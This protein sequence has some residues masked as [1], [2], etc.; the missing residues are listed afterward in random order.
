MSGGSRIWRNT[1]LQPAQISSQ[2]RNMINL[3]RKKPVHSRSEAIRS[4]QANAVALRRFGIIRCGVF[5]WIA[6]RPSA[7]QRGFLPLCPD[8]VVEL[9]SPSNSSAD[10]RRKMALDAANGAGL[11]WLLL[12][13]SRS[14]RDLERSLNASV[15]ERL[16]PGCGPTVS[17]QPAQ[18][19][20]DQPTFM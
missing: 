13:D 10:L 18:G 8:L 16:P 20:R 5:G 12:P 19:R 1:E 9:A 6:G 11:G 15:L 2:A 4:L 3:N 17:R 7:R 14:V